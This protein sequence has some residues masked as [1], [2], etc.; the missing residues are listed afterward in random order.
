[1]QAS[2]QNSMMNFRLDLARELATTCLE[3]QG[4]NASTADARALAERLK[5]WQRRSLLSGL[6]LNVYEWKARGRI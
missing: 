5:E 1:M 2:L 6:I 3:L 4:E